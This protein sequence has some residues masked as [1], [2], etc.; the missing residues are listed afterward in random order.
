MY[1]AYKYESDTFFLMKLKKCLDVSIF[2]DVYAT[3]RKEIKVE[4]HDN[5]LDLE[6]TS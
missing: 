3:G 1:N 4:F 5:S 6:Q 2:V